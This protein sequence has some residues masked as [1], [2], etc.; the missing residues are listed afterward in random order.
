MEQKGRWKYI[1]DLLSLSYIL[2]Y[3]PDPDFHIFRAYIVQYQHILYMVKL[4]NYLIQ[5]IIKF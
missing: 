5:Q 1:I 3:I 2:K 4:I